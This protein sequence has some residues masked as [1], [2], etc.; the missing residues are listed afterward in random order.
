DPMEHR[1]TADI[2]DL[3]PA[4]QGGFAEN[5]PGTMWYFAASYF[6]YDPD[7]FGAGAPGREMNLLNNSVF[8]KFNP[9]W[10][11]TKFFAD[12]TIDHWLD[13]SMRARIEMDGSIKRIDVDPTDPANNGVF[14]TPVPEPA[15]A[16]TLLALACLRLARRR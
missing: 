2:R 5:T 9:D 4:A 12:G 10:N 3:I 6:V 7:R 1:L 11:G 15:G 14:L 16:C 13:T 8:R